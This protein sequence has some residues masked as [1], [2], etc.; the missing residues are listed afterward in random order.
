[1]GLFYRN[2]SEEIKTN[3]KNFKIP[4]FI[5]IDGLKQ[6]GRRK[7]KPSEFVSPIFGVAVKDEVVAPF[8]N[9]ATGDLGKQFD[10]IR[11]NPMKDR[12][13]YEEFK[14]VMITNKTREPE[15][16]TDLNWPRQG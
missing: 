6:P 11:E 7:Y 3:N 1:M 2:K 13:T 16:E 14:G 10:F 5:K 8:V 15:Q 9:K 12:S 4:Q